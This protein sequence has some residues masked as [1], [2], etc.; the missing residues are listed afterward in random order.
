MAQILLVFLK[1][2]RKNG[3]KT[4]MKYDVRWIYSNLVFQMKTFCRKNPRVRQKTSKWDSQHHN[5]SQKSLRFESRGVIWWN[6][7][8]C[9]HLSSAGAMVTH[10]RFFFEYLRPR[11]GHK[12]CE[13][14]RSSIVV[15]IWMNATRFITYQAVPTRSSSKQACKTSTKTI[16]LN[17][18]SP[19]CNT[20]NKRPIMLDRRLVK[21]KAW[22]CVAEKR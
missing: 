1:Y 10:L 17:S 22:T 11:L 6:M 4:R 20:R 8:C 3:F 13:R 7:I 21:Q 15:C 5:L 16:F 12:Y 18:I 19:W 2:M 14:L 9:G